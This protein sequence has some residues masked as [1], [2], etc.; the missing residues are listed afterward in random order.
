MNSWED[1]RGPFSGA[2]PRRTTLSKIKLNSLGLMKGF[3]FDYVY[4]FGDDWE[5]SVKVM[6]TDYQP[7]DES[8]MYGCYGG[9]RNCPS[10]DCG[11]PWGYINLL[12]IVGDPGH[13]HHEDKKE[14]LGEFDPE[15]FKPYEKTLRMQRFA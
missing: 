7:K 9:A 10:E 2:K 4:D 8:L 14:W 12:E 1:D 6:D 13:K 15:E 5:R 3:V 11:G